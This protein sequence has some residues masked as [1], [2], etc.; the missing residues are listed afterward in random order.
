MSL[1]R[2]DKH[3]ARIAGG[4]EKQAQDVATAGRRIRS[5]MVRESRGAPKRMNLGK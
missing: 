2:F 5:V 4:K 3:G 1:R